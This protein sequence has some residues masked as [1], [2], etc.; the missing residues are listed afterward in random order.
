MISTASDAFMTAGD[1]VSTAT[2]GTYEVLVPPGT[3]LRRRIFSLPPDHWGASVVGMEPIE[4]PV[5]V[6]A[7]ELPPIW[8]VIRTPD[9]ELNGRLVDADGRAIEG[10]TVVAMRTYPIQ[11]HTSYQTDGEGRFVIQCRG[12]FSPTQFV[13]QRPNSKAYF[14]AEV[15]TE[16]PLVLRVDLSTADNSRGSNQRTAP[17]AD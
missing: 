3:T 10:S 9:F 2:D 11:A 12:E 13:V 17:L 8:L 1:L 7:V 4:I 6:D 5:G 14:N 15:V 16:E